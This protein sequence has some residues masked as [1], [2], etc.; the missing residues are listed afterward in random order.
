MQVKGNTILVQSQRQYMCWWILT[1]KL[2][3]KSPFSQG[4]ESILHA[5]KNVHSL[6]RNIIKSCGVATPPG[7]FDLLIVIGWPQPLP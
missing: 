3:Q 7:S 4:S 5:L 2:Y 6:K 1:D